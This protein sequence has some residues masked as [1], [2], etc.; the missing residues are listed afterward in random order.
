MKRT[1]IVFLSLVLNPYWISN[2]QQADSAGHWTCSAGYGML[3]YQSGYALEASSGLEISVGKMIHKQFKWESGFR[4][5]SNLSQSEVFIRLG[6]FHQRGVWRPSFS[7]EN[8]ITHRADFESNTLLLKETNEA[9]LKDI[10]I[11]YISSHTEMLCFVVKK[12][13]TLSLLEIDFGTHYKDMGKVLRLQANFIR[14][15]LTF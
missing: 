8:G 3:L 14:I 13:W 9:M 7:I 5:G 2:A 15:G 4:F 6:C 12:K 11:V 1:V 10:G